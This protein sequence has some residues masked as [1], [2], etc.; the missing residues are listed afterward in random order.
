MRLDLKLFAYP[1]Y[2]QKNLSQVKI[3]KDVIAPS[4]PARCLG[5][6]WQHNLSASES[7]ARRAFFSLGSTGVFHS[8]LNP[9]SAS[10]I[11]ETC[12][13]PILLYGCETWL[14]LSPRSRKCL[15]PIL[16]TS[17]GDFQ[18]VSNRPEGMI[19]SF[20]GNGPLLV[21]GDFNAH[22]GSDSGP[23]VCEDANAPGIL[24]Q[25][26]INLS[27]CTLSL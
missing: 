6:Q 12:I 20:Q 10:S 17:T 5:V 7:K 19:S 8:K 9:L 18:G 14:D 27:L 21:T 24:L 2:R 4:R 1:K 16:R 11:F 23:R 15:S 22:L 3:G 25:D 26:L 13:I